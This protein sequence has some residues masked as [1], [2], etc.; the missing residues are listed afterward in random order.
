MEK[1]NPNKKDPKK[2][3]AEKL[4]KLKPEI[5]AT[6]RKAAMATFKKSYVTVNRYLDGHVPNIV[7]GLDLLQ[8]FNNQI[9]NR[10][11]KLKKL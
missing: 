5:T 6:D 11:E 4:L 7:F 2:I 10:A 8:F 9:K 3:C 1:G